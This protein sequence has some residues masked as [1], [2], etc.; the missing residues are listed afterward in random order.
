ME[1]AIVGGGIVGLGLALSLHQRGLTCRVYEA[2]P[3]VKEL[4]DRKSTRLNSSHP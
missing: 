3:E 1:T 2:V 4:G